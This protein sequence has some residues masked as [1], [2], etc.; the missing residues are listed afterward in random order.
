MK[1]TAIPTTGRCLLH[2]LV[3]SLVVGPSMATRPALAQAAGEQAP[4]TFSVGTADVLLD[5]VVRDKK[6]NLVRDLKASDFE[7][8]EDGKPQAMDSFQVISKDEALSTAVAAAPAAGA[9][10]SGE[11]PAAASAP[12]AEPPP[13]SAA[14]TAPSVIAFVF[15]RMSVNAR[16]MAYKAAM[17]YIT[18]GHVEG[19][20]R[21]LRHRHR[22]PHRQPFTTNL[23]LVKLG[24]DRAL[25][26]S[27]TSYATA[28]DRTD[29]R[30]TVDTLTSNQNI[31]NAA[32]GA[33]TNA[34][35]V[36]GASAAAAFDQ[37]HIEMA[38]T[39][40]TLEQDAQG[41]ASTNG[42]LAI[43]NG[44]K[45]IPGR[46][47]LLFFSEGLVI[48]ANVQAQ[49]KAVIA[50]AN[51]ANVSVY[52]MDAGGLR[53]DSQTAETRKEIEQASVRRLDQLGSAGTTRPTGT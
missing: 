32:G 27:N 37:M 10:P 13:P 38:R 22:P 43:V 47:T 28:D 30:N 53:V 5:V 7:I 51:R 3:L 52:A 49:F 31:I 39:F 35:V 12:A 18:K 36:A 41:Y 26:Q 42:L 40:E 9:R 17:T 33:G 6:G 11:A 25:Q 24:F 21:H 4:P 1:K 23:D 45:P 29:L 16:D 44:L 48:P 50:A 20:R 2:L 14:K 46:K 34:S 15:D 8:Y 19:R